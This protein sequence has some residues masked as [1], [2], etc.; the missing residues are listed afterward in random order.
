M[1]LDPRVCTTAFELNNGMPNGLPLTILSQS[2][3]I[4]DDCLGMKLPAV[5]LGTWQGR[6]TTPT[7][8]WKLRRG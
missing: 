6:K 8:W 7:T 1:T 3:A 4:F 5:G 2:F